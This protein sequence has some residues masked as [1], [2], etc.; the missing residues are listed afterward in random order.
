V[1]YWRI[2]TLFVLANANDREADLMAREWIDVQMRAWAKHHGIVIVISSSSND[3]KG[4]DRV[5]EPTVPSGIINRH[6]EWAVQ[7]PDSGDYLMSID[8][9]DQD[10]TTIESAEVNIEDFTASDASQ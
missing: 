10:K 3:I 6:G 8:L 1:E 5:K 2:K 7:A 9:Y 4:G